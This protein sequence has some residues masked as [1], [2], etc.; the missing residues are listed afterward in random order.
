LGNNQIAGNRT[1]SA[2]IWTFY[3]HENLTYPFYKLKP[4]NW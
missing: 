4:I 2:A 3:S 1:D